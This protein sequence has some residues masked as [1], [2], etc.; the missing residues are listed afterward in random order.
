MPKRKRNNRAEL[1]ITEPI[2]KDSYLKKCRLCLE[3]TEPRP[4]CLT[5]PKIKAQFDTALA[6]I[7]LQD[8]DTLS[9][10]I[11]HKCV[12]FIQKIIEFKENIIKNQ[13]F[14]LILNQKQEFIEKR[15]P[16]DEVTFADVLIKD[17]FEIKQEIEVKEQIQ[18]EKEE[19]I[20]NCDENEGDEYVSDQNDPS[21]TDSEKDKVEI[22]SDDDEIDDDDEGNLSINNSLSE[23]E[24]VRMDENETNGKLRLPKIQKDKETNR[25]W[26]PFCYK[27]YMNI[28]YLARH[29]KLR[30]PEYN[31]YYRKNS[32]RTIWACKFCNAEYRKR[33]A[34]KDHA[35]VEHFGRDEYT[36]DICNYKT[37]MKYLIRNHMRGVH[38]KERRGIYRKV[39]KPTE[40]ITCKICK[41]LSAS[42]SLHFVHMKQHEISE[43][44]CPTCNLYFR[45]QH[46]LDKHIRM[47]HIFPTLPYS[48]NLCV[49]ARFKSQ[50]ILNLH[51]QLHQNPNRKPFPCHL[52]ELQFPKETMLQNHLICHERN[53]IECCQLCGLSLQCDSY[54]DHVMRH[55]TKYEDYE[56]VCH[57]CA[58]RFISHIDL[59]IHIKTH[60]NDD[61]SFTCDKCQINIKTKGRFENHI[62]KCNGPKTEFPCSFCPAVFMTKSSKY[63]HEVKI[64][65]GWFCKRCNVTFDRYYSYKVHR[66]TEQHRL[67]R[68]TQKI[69]IA[70]KRAQSDDKR[71]GYKKKLKRI[72]LE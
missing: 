5:D 40:V 12:D 26:C 8:L 10:V 68:E 32:K 64:H 28:Y 33:C 6:D 70:E 35:L 15:E 42:R 2:N 18:I 59:K 24:Y 58:W 14:L 3:K 72:H 16:L 4:K 25:V 46:V 71:L 1:E 47:T 13:D 52:C 21:Y 7:E 41:H 44:Q 9:L 29:G 31:W 56:H 65:K 17:D 19:V 67:S 27:Q 62:A 51:H 23:S 55:V 20:S 66:K 57:I 30:H 49:S 45:T 48:C 69:R 38:L 61:V 39:T 54:S 37:P 36:C 43:F 60:E 53:E 50:E 63:R 22:E 34:L 11:C